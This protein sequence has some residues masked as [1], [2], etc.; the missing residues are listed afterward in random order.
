MLVFK[1]FTKYK[2]MLIELA[3]N[4]FKVK[5]AGSYLGI[6]WA[7]IQPI[8][9]ILMYWFI[10]QV[11]FHAKGIKDV[12]YVLTLMTGLIPWFFF[13]EALSSGTS[14]MIEYS[15][16]VKKV[17]FP[18]EILPIVKVISS[19]FVH[20]FFV[21]IVLLLYKFYGYNPDLYTLQILYYI[22]STILLVLGISYMTCSIIVFFRDVGN[23]I[24]IILQVGMWMTPI[25]WEITMLPSN[26]QYIM[27]INPM[28][29]II[30]GYKDA[31]INKVWFWEHKLL[32]L[33]FW[34]F[35][36]T[37]LF[38]GKHMFKKLKIHFADVL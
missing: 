18:I 3:K 25:L 11:A 4:D 13:S 19:L 21:A 35:T 38:I 24:S 12:P 22:F 32:T 20:M 34:I 14:S 5:Y 1:N 23:L 16:L 26:L 29:Y 6:I 36:I 17:V 15:Y 9:T 28:Y 31:L 2:V 30:E 37:F 33:Y 7:F 8:I 27:K 10:F